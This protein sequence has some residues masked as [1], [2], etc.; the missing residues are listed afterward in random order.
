VPPRSD[1]EKRATDGRFKGARRAPVAA[2][3]AANWSLTRYAGESA[4]TS[5]T[6]LPKMAQFI[7][8]SG[9]VARVG[10][11]WASE[12]RG[13]PQ[14]AMDFEADARPSRSGGGDRAAPGRSRRRV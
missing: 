14:F 6:R 9:A 7:S 13:P 3:H 2:Y 1:E 12:Q 10:A 5:P 11:Q 4:A 8:S